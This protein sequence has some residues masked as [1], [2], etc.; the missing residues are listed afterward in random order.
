MTTEPRPPIG[1]VGLG[2]MGAAVAHLITQ[3]DRDVIGWEYDPAVVAEVNQRH[4]NERF[5]PGVPLSPRLRATRDVHEVFRGASIV[6]IA[7]P[8]R[9]IQPTLG[10][11][12]AAGGV[13]P[14]TIVVNMAKGIDAAT[15]LTAFQTVSALFP[16]NPCVMLSGPS[17]ANEFARGEPTVVVLAGQS[18]THLTQVA[19]VLDSRHFRTRFSH[20][21]MGVELGGVLKNIYAIGLGLFDGLNVGSVNFRAAYLTIAL[22]EMTL[23]GVAMGARA[24]TFA[25]LAGLGDLLATSMSEHSHNRR[26]GEL[27]SQGLSLEQIQAQMGVLPEGYNTLRVALNLAEK[28][29]V[30]LSLAHGLWSVIC[31]RYTAQQFIY[32]F[33]RN[34]VD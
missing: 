10:P 19:Q 30:N 6:F 33:I 21:T 1:I 12:C 11:V 26:L 16:R 4:T 32:S 27:L 17:I 31:G 8:S 13:S 24:E 29:H 2:N 34:F 5:L 22:E 20:D 23:L 28:L 7:L 3:H 14:D 15:G 9:F 25:Y 18:L